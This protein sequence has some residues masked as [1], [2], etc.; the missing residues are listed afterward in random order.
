M[1]ITI[2]VTSD[3]NAKFATHKRRTLTTNPKISELCQKLDNV[4]IA[5]YLTT[6]LFLYS[7]T[8]VITAVTGV[9]TGGTITDLHP[10]T[11]N[12]RL[13][14]AAIAIRIITNTPPKIITSHLYHRDTPL[15]SLPLLSLF[16]QQSTMIGERIISVV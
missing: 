1:I 2:L 15:T 3:H 12:H 16:P 9:M 13:I 5:T 14:E 6:V 8:G 4:V 7:F 11:I 10:L